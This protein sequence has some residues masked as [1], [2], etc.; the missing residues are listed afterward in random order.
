MPT[1]TILAL[2]LSLLVFSACAPDDLAG[3]RTKADQGDAEAQYNL[4]VMYSKGRGVPQHFKE[5]VRWYRLAADQG[6]AQ[7]QV[8]LGFMY[9]TGLGVSQDYTQAHMW[10]NLGASNGFADAAKQRDQLAAKMSPRDLSEAQ[11]L[12]T[13]WKPKE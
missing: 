6:Y 4:G 5:A 3:L 1:R 9:A 2:M 10:Y 11:R 12:A 13:E 7:A 8:H